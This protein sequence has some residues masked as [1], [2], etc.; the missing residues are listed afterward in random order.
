MTKLP[1]GRKPLPDE[2]FIDRAKKITPMAP[3]ER[4]RA[5]EKEEANQED[6]WDNWTDGD[7]G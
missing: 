1:E 5:K 7:I 2:W 4:R 6:D 3:E